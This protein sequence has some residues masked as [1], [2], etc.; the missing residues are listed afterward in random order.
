MLI[1]GKIFGV[2]T[3]ALDK[4]KK[5]GQNPR[6]MVKVKLYRQNHTKSIHCTLTKGKKG[7]YI[8]IKEESD[9]INKQ[10]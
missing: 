4:K 3:T 5:D 6:Q 1:I 10:I 8:Y 7:K 9:Q 2:F